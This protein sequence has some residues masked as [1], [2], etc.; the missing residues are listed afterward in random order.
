MSFAALEQRVMS[1]IMDGHVKLYSHQVRQLGKSRM[2]GMMYGS[3]KA[4]FQPHSIPRTHPLEFD[5]QYNFAGREPRF[6]NVPVYK[7]NTKLTS[8]IICGK[9]KI[10]HTCV[11]YRML[12]D[13]S[14]WVD[15]NVAAL[16]WTRA[17]PKEQLEQAVAT[18]IMMG[19][20]PVLLRAF[21]PSWE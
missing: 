19:H 5:S 15:P 14:S 1:T 13:L 7:V 17:T 18:S 4:A 20:T 9:E 8:Q 6:G 10:P 11:H 2:L 16:V 12:D 21:D 3:G